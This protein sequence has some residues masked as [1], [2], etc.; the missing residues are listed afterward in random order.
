MLAMP[1]G[2]HA[3]YSSWLEKLAMCAS[4]TLRE[5]VLVRAMCVPAMPLFHPY[6]MHILPL[7]CFQHCLFPCRVLSRD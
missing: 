5:S 4:I 1:V 7:P 2:I 3:R 6:R